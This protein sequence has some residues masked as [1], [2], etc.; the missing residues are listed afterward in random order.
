MGMILGGPKAWKIFKKGN[1]VCAMHWVNNEPAIVLFPHPKPMGAAG[2]IICLSAAHKYV[3][4][5]GYPTPYMIQASA[6][7]AQVMGLDI[8]KM[9][10]SLIADVITEHI[11]DLVKMPPEPDWKEKEKTVGEVSLLVDGNKIAEHEVTDRP[12][13]LILPEHMH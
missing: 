1:I 10:I 7:A 12:P 11:E 8:T 5:D 9:T 2:Y 6:T 13:E 4:S 3:N